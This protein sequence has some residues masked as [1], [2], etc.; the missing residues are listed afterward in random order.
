VSGGGYV[1][2]WLMRQI[3]KAA[4]GLDLDFAEPL[5]DLRRRSRYLSVSTGEAWSLIAVFLG[6][7]WQTGWFSRPTHWGAGASLAVPGPWL[8]S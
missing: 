4:P 7:S 3:G 6:G 5:E 1:G 8:A 2:S